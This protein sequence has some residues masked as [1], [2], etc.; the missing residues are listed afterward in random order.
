[1]KKYVATIFLSSMALG[2]VGCNEEKKSQET[3]YT[4]E[5]FKAHKAEREKKLMK[6]KSNPGELALT[7]NCVNASRAD[8][9]V[10]WSARG[11]VKAPPPLTAE[12]LKK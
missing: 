12:D 10:T 9:S 11:G 8:S 7:P 4:V 6:C 3:V 1:M 5:W 2:L